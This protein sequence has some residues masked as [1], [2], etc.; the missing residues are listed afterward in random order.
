MNGRDM[1]ALA[2]GLDENTELDNIETR[3][4]QVQ[5]LAARLDEFGIPYQRPVGGHA[6][7]VP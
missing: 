4:R 3:I 7:F 1:A 2:V 5:Y 6:I